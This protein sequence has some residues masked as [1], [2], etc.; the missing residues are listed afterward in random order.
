MLSL[1]PQ[2]CVSLSPTFV[3]PVSIQVY[4]HTARTMRDDF[5]FYA[6]LLPGEFI[7]ISK[8]PIDHISLQ[9]SLAQAF[10]AF[11]IA[12]RPPDTERKRFDSFQWPSASGSSLLLAPKIRVVYTRHP[13]TGEVATHTHPFPHLPK[14]TI[15]GAHPALLTLQATKFRIY[16]LCNPPDILTEL[17][18]MRSTYTVHRSFRKDWSAYWREDAAGPAVSTKASGVKRKALENAN[19]CHTERPRKYYESQPTI[20]HCPDESFGG[21][22]NSF[23]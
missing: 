23:P 16:H 18:V 19:I 21:R 7:R 5:E 6:G 12:F 17:F 14:F 3:E 13:I 4:S 9:P 22:M 1:C 15:S 8:M 20:V 11:N 2:D 10:S